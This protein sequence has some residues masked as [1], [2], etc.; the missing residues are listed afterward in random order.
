MRGHLN[1]LDLDYRTHQ[2]EQMTLLEKVGF[3]AQISADYLGT[4]AGNVPLQIRLGP[5]NDWQSPSLK[6]SM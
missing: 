2:P 1:C 5:G 4:R 3:A 6:T